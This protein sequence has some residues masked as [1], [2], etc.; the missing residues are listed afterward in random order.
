MNLGV[1]AASA[2]T[3]RIRAVSHTVSPVGRATPTTENLAAYVLERI[4]GALPAGVRVH[5]VRMQEDR[6]LWSDVYGPDDGG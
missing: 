2:R 4:G 5:R 6:D 1:V 3:V